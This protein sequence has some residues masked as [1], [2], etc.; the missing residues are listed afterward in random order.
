MMPPPATI[1]GF[2]AA[3]SIVSAFSAWLRDIAGLNGISGS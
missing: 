2:S 3:L 1:S